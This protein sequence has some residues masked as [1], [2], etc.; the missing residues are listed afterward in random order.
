MSFISMPKN[1]RKNKADTDPKGFV[2]NSMI[3]TLFDYKTFLDSRDLNGS[4]ALKAPEQQKNIAVIGGGASGLVAAYELSKI[5]NIHVTLF[6]AADRLGGRMDSVYVQDGDLNQKVFEL[7]CMRFPPTSYTLYHYLNKFGL[8]ATPNFPDPGKVPTKLLYENEVINW[9]AGQPTPDNED[10]QRIGD[11]FGK[12]INFLLGDASAP[13]IENPSKLFD[14]WAIYQ[15]DPTE[16]TKQKVVDAW[17]GILTQYVGVTYFDAVFELAQNRLLV[18]RP[19]TQ[20]DM[21]KFGALGVGAGGFGPLYGVDFVEILRLFANGWEDNQE[22][23]LDG[24][25]ALTQAFEFAL[26]DARTASGKPKVSIELNA[27]VKS[28]V[29]LAGDKYAL[30]VSNN[31]GQ[32]ISSQFDSVV[33]ATTTRA[34][35]YMGLTIANDLDSCESEKSQDLI[36]QNVKVA[37][38]NL[39]LMNS[40]KLFVTT[41]S[42]FWYPEN[43]PQGNE[44]PFNIQTDELMRGLYCLNY[45]EDVDG[46]PNTQGKGVVLI[47]YVWGDDSSKLLALSPEERFQQFLP[48]IYAVNPEFA[49]LLEKQTQKVSCIDWESTSNIYG[50]FK[51]NY[52][53]QEQSNKDAFFQYQQENQGLFLAGDSIS[54]AGGWLEGA[55]PTGINAACAAAKYVGAKVIDNS[56]LTDIAKNMY[57]YG[58]GSNTGFCTL[59]ESG[60]LSASS[61]AEYQFGQGDFSIEATVRTLSP[62]TVV[63]NKSTAGG[64]GGYLLVIQ[65]DGSIKFA[66]DNGETYYQIESELSDVKDGNW[67]SVVAV[68]KDGELTLH[69]DGKLLESTQ[70]GAS[71]QSPLN[72]SNS[73]DVLIGSVQQ[74]QE[75][76]IHYTGDVSQ[77]RLW[78]RALSEQEVASQYEQ[79]TIIDKEGLVAHWPLAINTDDISENENN[80]SVNGDVTFESVS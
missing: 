1:F 74:N 21:N 59:K 52:P 48:A 44:L 69:L 27:K 71:N 77:V 41:E 24:I 70:S 20:E 61:I 73:L 5:D 46:K 11:D 45:D 36:S 18:S 56:P 28:L 29:K 54:W 42:K 2:P 32:V 66:T 37:I 65:P 43:N 9:P 62:G 23:L 7:G 55:M 53:G 40:S 6:E 13:D 63:G 4:I 10:F 8:K 57:D 78:R 31:G 64:S 76:F 38:R 12:I 30:S 67:H 51:L 49:A 26:L 22:L 17:Q 33:V 39:H 3:D 25:G 68:R 16:Q 34:M 15:S 58:I 50:A 79:G 75:P 80:V 19:W 47:S 14:Y 35:E 60:F 72:V